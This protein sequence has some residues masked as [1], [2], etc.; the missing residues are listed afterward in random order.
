M[1]C[2]RCL[3]LKSDVLVTR[4]CSRCS[5]R[6]RV[7]VDAAHASGMGVASSGRPKGDVYSNVNVALARR[8]GICLYVNTALKRYKREQTPLLLIAAV[9]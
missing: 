6:S 2:S 8:S 5:E 7:H 4:R 1:T 9:I 3:K